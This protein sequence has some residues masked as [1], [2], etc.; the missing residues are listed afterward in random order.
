MAA[1][2]ACPGCGAQIDPTR[3]LS[4]P[5]C[6]RLVATMKTR[7]VRVPAPPPAPEAAPAAAPCPVTDCGGSIPAGQDRC[8]FCGAPA[9]P[10]GAPAT[11]AARV[12]IGGA[13][14]RMIACGE[15]LPIGRQ[16]EFSPLAGPL[17]GFDTVSRRHAILE[18]R[19]EGLFA[20]DLGSIN[21]TFVDDRRL[22]PNVAEPVPPGAR[23]RL[24]SSV[25]IEVEPAT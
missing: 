5:S 24:G 25:A 11:A 14:E 10:A 16:H 13:A 6:R 1:L 4:C 18:L 17:A 7:P 12:R 15:R 2:I 3:T 19:S 8:G 20:T 9:G 23:L 21:G 22:A